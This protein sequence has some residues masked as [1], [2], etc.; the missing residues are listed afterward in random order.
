MEKRRLG[1]TGHMST[2]VAFG[3]AGIGT[4]T[5]EVADKAVETALAAGVNHFDV[6]PT[7]GDAE[8]RLKPWMQQ[9]RSQ[10]FLGCKTQ[11]RGKQEA[12]EQLYRSLDRLG[13]SSFDLFQLHAVTDWDNLDRAMGPGGALEAILEAQ[14]EGLL[15]YV[16][17]TGHG[18]LAPELYNE[19]L[20]RFDF[21]TVMFPVN[22]I[23]HSLPAYRQHYDLLM[24]TCRQKDVGVHAIK[25]ISR[26][27]WTAVHHGQQ[28]YATW[29]EPFDKQ[30]EIDSAVWFTLSQAGLTTACSVGD[31]GLL[32]KFLDAA[33]RF[34]PLSVE[35]QQAL[36][37]SAF[38]YS[39]SFHAA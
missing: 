16:G 29:Y 1:R 30:A 36:I 39:H 9:I 3:A 10:I 26:G 11:L 23:L 4:V 13:V 18:L 22:F 28:Q 15:R 32:P 8:L 27:A 33:E 6:A 35:Q 24:E 25:A 20:R 37:A 7:Y 34:Q 12:R 17:I 5:Q 31:V 19:A 2:V 38:H 21:D 14:Q